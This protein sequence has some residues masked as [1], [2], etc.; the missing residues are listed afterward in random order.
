MASS[1]A[2]RAR[3]KMPVATQRA[4]VEALGGQADPIKAKELGLRVSS[5]CRFRCGKIALKLA[6]MALVSFVR[7]SQERHLYRF[8]KGRVALRTQA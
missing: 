3:A 1:D 6:E 7:Y 2:G 4:Y 8:T 5:L